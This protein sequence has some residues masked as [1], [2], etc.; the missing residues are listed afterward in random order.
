MYDDV[1]AGLDV[2]TCNEADVQDINDELLHMRMLIA[3]DR[4]LHSELDFD[5]ALRRWHNALEAI[6]Q[7]SN[8][9]CGE[10]VLTAVIHLSIAQAHIHM[11]NH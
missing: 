8:F 7:P 10:L 11:G 3:Y 5:E 1:K 9:K 6:R 2:L 4:V